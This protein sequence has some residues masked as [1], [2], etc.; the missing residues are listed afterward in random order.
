MAGIGKRRKIAEEELLMTRKEQL[1]HVGQKDEHMRLMGAEQDPEAICKKLLDEES[2]RRSCLLFLAD[3]IKFADTLNPNRWGLTLSE[4]YIR[5]NVGMIE[6]LALFPNL[7]HCLLDLETMP[8]GLRGDSRVALNENVNDP[9]LGIYPSVPGSVSFNAAA[10]D[11]EALISLIQESHT[12]L[13]D[14]ASVTRRNPATKRAHSKELI[15]YLASC[16]ERDIPQPG[17]TR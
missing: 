13:V 16:L 4:D 5:L 6:V 17:Y 3:S 2:T 8:T 15:Q 9:S 12:T 1:E 14:H 11:F 7:V 10:A